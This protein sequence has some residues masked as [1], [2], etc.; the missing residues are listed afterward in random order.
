MSTPDITFDRLLRQRIAG[1]GLD[2]PAD[3]V[4]WMGAIQAQDYAA[5]KW[6]VGLRSL[7]GSDAA[8][9]ESFTNGELIRTHVMRPTWHFVAPEDV[10][11]MQMLTS[12]RVNA[13][14]AYEY[15]RLELDPAVFRR[16]T[17][18]LVKT[19]R[20]GKQLTRT[21]L[22]A[23]LERAGIPATGL[24]LAH[25]LAR[26]ELDAILCSGGRRGKQF[27]YALL[28]ERAP[29]ARHLQR[30][31][32]L[33]ELAQRYF[34]SH[35]PAT[36]RDYAWWSGLSSADVRNGLEM[37]KSGLTRLVIDG[38]DYWMTVDPPAA[39]LSPRAVQ[40]LG[41]Y[42]EY[43]VGYT[44]RAA[45]FDRSHAA[46]LDDRHNPLFNHTVVSRGRIIGT[47]KR[48]V[49]NDALT[50]QAG[51]FAAPTEAEAKALGSAVKQLARF[52]G[53]QAA[54]PQL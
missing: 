13:V 30:D 41:N 27:T 37:V 7:H 34:A 22:G 15:H 16:T 6:A 49:M 12:P 5:A 10:R 32:A 11:W 38:Q 47:W 21:E 14:M 2:N 39:R 25:I 53:V 9:E 31:E 28:D 8:V 33:T 18:V 17:R 40:L 51:L 20:D 45:I 48:T 46:H 52:L 4:R 35:G 1:D 50:V 43:I 54:P 42:D 23:A 3:V 19:L 29:R 44:D 26:A 36:L 24:R